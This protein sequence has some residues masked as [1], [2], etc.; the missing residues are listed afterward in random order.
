MFVRENI[1]R[2]MLKST[3]RGLEGLESQTFSLS[4]WSISSKTESG[5]SNRHLTSL[6]I[7]MSHWD[8]KPL[9]GFLWKHFVKTLRRPKKRG[10]A[11]IVNLDL[12]LDQKHTVDL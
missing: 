12:L 5:R 10:T 8:I 1:C 3:V 4:A 2:V 9:A 11:V 7:K 6:N